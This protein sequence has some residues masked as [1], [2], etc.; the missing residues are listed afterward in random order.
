M[1]SCVLLHCATYWKYLQ[2]HILHRPI[3]SAIHIDHLQDSMDKQSSYCQQINNIRW[4]QK[5]SFFVT[6]FCF[7][8]SLC[9]FNSTMLSTQRPSSKQANPAPL[10]CMH[11]EFPWLHRIGRGVRSLK[12]QTAF[13]QPW[14]FQMLH[15]ITSHNNF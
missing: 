8:Q 4:V 9:K 15:C 13:N 6:K 11:F 5:S 12:L 14:Y 2:L 1:N 7:V 10:K 3:Y